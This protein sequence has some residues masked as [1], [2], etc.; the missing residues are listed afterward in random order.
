MSQSVSILLI[1]FYDSYTYNLVELL[2]SLG[3]VPT[4]VLWDSKQDLLSLLRNSDA[5]VLSPGPGSPEEYLK[6]VVEDSD[7]QSNSPTIRLRVLLKEA[8]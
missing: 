5:L 6:C 3:A 7:S 2:R 1:D 4:V 8:A